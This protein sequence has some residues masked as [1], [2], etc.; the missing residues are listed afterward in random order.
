MARFAGHLNRSFMH[1]QYSERTDWRAVW[2]LIKPYWRSDDKWRGR[3]LLL[4]VV[5]LALGLLLSQINYALIIA[6]AIIVLFSFI[7]VGQRLIY[8][9][10]QSKN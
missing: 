5:V 1:I 7:T 10:R 6:L 8:A 3:A 2:Q 9:W 4:S